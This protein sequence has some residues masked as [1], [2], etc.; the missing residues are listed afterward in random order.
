MEN[1]LQWEDVMDLSKDIDAEA[2]INKCLLKR[3][4]VLFI[5]DIC[6]NLLIIIQVSL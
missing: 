4:K 1:T 6:I 2:N 5:L 3:E